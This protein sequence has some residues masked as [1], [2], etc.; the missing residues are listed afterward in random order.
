MLNN[1]PISNDSTI[2]IDFPNHSLLTPLF[3]DL[4]TKILINLDDAAIWC[5]CFV[6]KKFNA[7]IINL[8]KQYIIPI[9]K[10][11]EMYKHS[12]EA[13][14]FDQLLWIAEFGFPIHEL[15]VCGL[16][17]HNNLEM[18]QWAHKRGCKMNSM[19]YTNAIR[20]GSID[21]LNW[22]DE[23]KCPVGSFSRANITV[24]KWAHEKN[25]SFPSA[26]VIAAK[27]G[28]ISLLVWLQIINMLDIDL[29]YS[30]AAMNGQ[31]KVLEW[32][33]SMRYEP[34]INDCYCAARVG[35][36]EALL[37]FHEHGCVFDTHIY[38]KVISGRSLSI[39][40][41]LHKINIP[42]DTKTLETAVNHKNLELFKWALE[43]GCPMNNNIC[44]IAAREGCVEILKYAIEKGFPYNKDTFAAAA[45]GGNLEILNFLYKKGCEWDYFVCESAVNAKH[46]DILR[47][48]C[49]MGAPLDLTSLINI[50]LNFKNKSDHCMEESKIISKL[51]II[52]ESSCETILRNNNFMLKNI[53][54]QIAWLKINVCPKID[55]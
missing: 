10:I 53:D 43:N 11:N 50:M 39:W 44:N 2:S 33:Y 24:L 21:I 6:S 46:F 5:L 36:M 40:E 27:N 31:I 35:Q 52:S 18:L 16:A 30:N 9:P 23:I 19:T 48:L 38:T 14:D 20:N 3:R 26:S 49:G 32:L 1:I 37:W 15:I 51:E 8:F 55:S 22:L 54:W 7:T 45:H 4:L 12:I 25:H 42:W 13:G 34:N 17:K 47:W 41:Y 29:A 28:N